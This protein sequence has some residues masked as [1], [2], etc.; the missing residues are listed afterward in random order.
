MIKG[1]NNYTTFMGPKQSKTFSSTHMPFSIKIQDR[2][3]KG[4]ET[5]ERY[6]YRISQWDIECS[7][8]TSNKAESTK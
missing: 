3:Q 2:R 8:N 1:I 4:W 7:G 6:G 5:M